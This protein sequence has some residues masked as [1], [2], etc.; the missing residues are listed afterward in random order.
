MSPRRLSRTLVPFCFALLSP[1]ATRWEGLLL[2]QVRTATISGTV[3]DQTQSVLPG[4]TVKVTNVETGL[5]RTVLTGDLG[6]YHVPSLAPG[7]YQ[8]EAE[9]V[10]FQ[11]A[12]RSGITLTVGREAVV[13]FT[14]RVG[15]VAERVTVTAEAPLIESTT[16]TMGGLVDAKQMRD[17]PL[18]TRSFIELVP[19]QTGA[20]FAEAGESSATKGFGRKLAI[21]GTRY[22]ASVFL[23]DGAVMNDAAGSSG[24]AAQTMTGVETVR[25]FRVITNAYT[26]EHGRHTG[27]VI[28]A[29]TKSGTNEFHGSIFEFLR[30]DNL[31]ARNFFDRDPDNPQVRSNPPEFKRNQYGFAAGGPIRRDQSFFFGSY[32]GLRER[33]GLT[34]T[35]IVPGTAM[36]Q[37]FLRG[38]F[39]GIQPAVRPYLEA[40]PVP[41]RPDRP[42]GTAQF[43]TANTPTTDQDFLTG[44]IDHNFSASD[45]LFGRYTF[46]DAENFRAGDEGFN[47]GSRARTRNQFFTVEETHI[48]SP[49]L[50]NTAQFSFNRTNLDFFDLPLEGYT[51]PGGK[52]SFSDVTDAV[53]IISVSGLATWG[54]GSTNPK[55]HIQNNFQVKE[56]VFYTRGRHSLKFGGQLERLQFNQRSDFNAPGVFN[57]QSLEDFLRNDV[58]S[59]LF[60]K[61][62]SDNRRGWREN[63]IGLYLH[64]DISV[65][66]GLTLNLGLRYEFITV[67]TEVNGKVATIRDISVPHIY[68]VRPD[69]TDV[70]DPY[71][72]N[73]SLRN[74]APRLGFAW[75]P[76]GGGKTSLRGGFGIYH[77]QILPNAYITSGVRM[78]PFFSVAELFRENITIDFPNAFF[79]QRAALVASG[80]RPQADGFQWDIEQ[81]MVMKYSLDLQ[82]QVATDTILEAGYSGTRG[83]HLLRGAVMFN[84]TPS[85]IRDGRRLI[86]MDDPLPNP[87]WNRM[88]WRIT[89]GTS[90]YHALRLRVT[91]R[92]SRGF[93]FQSS[94]TFSKSTDDSSTWTGST[95]FNEADR[96]GYRTEKQHGRSA[97]DVRNSF[98]TNLV[99]D[100]AGANWT[101]VAGRLLGGWSVSGILRFNDGNPISLTADQPRKG[102]LSMRFVD[103]ST[104]DLV[105]GADQNPIRPQNPDEYFDPSSFRFPTPFFQGNVGRNHLIVPGVA[106]VDVSLMKNVR[107][108]AL[109]E[110]GALQF[111][112][113]FFN[114]FNRPNFGIPARNLFDREGRPRSN[115]GEITSTRTTSRQIQL[116]LKVLF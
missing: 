3:K 33:L 112:A 19:L 55:I 82:Q 104:L 15:E 63:L 21:V 67:P 78:A 72:R 88:R 75:D 84:T 109:G 46:D 93:Q 48:F 9:L 10:G 6:Q 115:A 2:A 96:R 26:A 36:R 56:D 73:P 27:A 57:F 61:P 12:V 94:Y 45:S 35:F 44:R 81:P 34:Q 5:V 116:A 24:S 30:N 66:Q 23:L 8:V 53:G 107:I 100:L 47:T 69:Q 102:R 111:R 95:D 29:V 114:L 16:A 22:N 89:D 50:I 42:D 51:F 65:R 54:G 87:F 108:G 77:D 97:F 90:D 80:G 86:L 76:F 105:P 64:D 68:T 60:V 92:F 49:G 59:G 99:Y 98:F 62:G 20:V 7:N 25:E 32:E 41:N 71:F 83:V 37:G 106:T 4:V 101:G 1:L 113:E 85:E 31:D 91:R 52:I 14:L 58:G 11:T 38:R 103:G 39:I 18:N 28:S 13:D 17:I 79:S 43:V 40:Y 110:S 74:F 70:G